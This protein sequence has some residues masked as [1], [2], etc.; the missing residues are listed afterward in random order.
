VPTLEYRQ[1]PHGRSTHSPAPCTAPGGLCTWAAP[2]PPVPP[3]TQGNKLIRL[4]V[5]LSKSLSRVKPIRAATDSVGARTIFPWICFHCSA[6]L[7]RSAAAA[8]ASTASP[9]PLL[10]SPPCG[11]G[12]VS[13]GGGGAVSTGGDGAVSTGGDGA[14]STGGGGAVLGAAGVPSALAGRVKKAAMLLPFP[15]AMLLPF[16]LG[17]GLALPRA[18]LCAFEEEE[19]GEDCRQAEQ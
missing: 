11:G 16:P 2:E 9:P 13:T 3:H 7:A 5:R 4:G 10:L 1:L 8:A 12:A 14:V 19:E 18:A 15:S 17:A 6:T